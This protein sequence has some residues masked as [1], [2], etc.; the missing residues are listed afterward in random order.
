MNETLQSDAD[1][2]E[3]TEVVQDEPSSRFSDAGV[4]ASVTTVDAETQF[5]PRK[6]S[7]GEE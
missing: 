1:P 5:R 7:R 6:M 3:E 4:Q 2:E